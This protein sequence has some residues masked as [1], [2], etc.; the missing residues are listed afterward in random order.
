[1]GVGLRDPGGGEGWRGE[2]SVRMGRGGKGRE[3][4]KPG[5][6]VEVRVKMGTTR[7]VS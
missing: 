2:T 7:N 6:R 4:N 1:M 5:K 3:V